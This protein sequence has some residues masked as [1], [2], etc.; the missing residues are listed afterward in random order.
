MLPENDRPSIFCS[1]VPR[2]LQTVQGRFVYEL[3]RQRPVVSLTCWVSSLTAVSPD[4]CLKERSIHA[5][6]TFL[7]YG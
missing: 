2:K 6:R 5:Y 7:Y 1:T 3:F 4:Q